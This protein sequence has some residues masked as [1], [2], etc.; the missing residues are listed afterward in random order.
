MNKITK[1]GSYP[2]III[3][4]ERIVS[5]NSSTKLKKP[6]VSDMVNDVDFDKI[7]EL[8]EG[9]F[10][11]IHKIIN[12]KDIYF[13][14]NSSSSSVDTFVNLRGKINVELWDPHTGNKII[15]EIAYI[16]KL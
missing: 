8:S 13:I 16:I 12:G 4:I 5:I 1:V 7:T 9:T 11:Y 14:A 15:P 6:W 2:K 10:T 3:S